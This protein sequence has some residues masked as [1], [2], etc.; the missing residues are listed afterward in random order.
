M[1]ILDQKIL[2]QNDI[3]FKNQMCLNNQQ[4]NEKKK[5]KRRALGDVKNVVKQQQKPHQYKDILKS[6]SINDDQCKP[7]VK[8]KQLL[9]KHEEIIEE[10]EFNNANIFSDGF[11]D[12]LNEKQKLSNLMMD[13]K[14]LPLLP[15]HS[16]G[17]FSIYNDAFHFEHVINDKKLKKNIKKEGKI[18]NFNDICQLF[19]IY[20]FLVKS[21]NKLNN[22]FELVNDG[23]VDENLFVPPNDW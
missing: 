16:I 3:N 5:Q 21:I 7:T 19:Y 14:C 6:L 9:M 15:T 13:A 18:S 10:I 11:H 23:F 12:I 8:P 4:S 22:V 1:F 2:N 17:E 20:F